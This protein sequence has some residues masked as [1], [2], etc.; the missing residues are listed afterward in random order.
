MARNREEGSEKVI[1]VTILTMSPLPMIMYNEKENNSGII[2]LILQ[3][4]SILSI[5]LYFFYYGP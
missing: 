5:I 4:A 1:Q 3:D 2:K